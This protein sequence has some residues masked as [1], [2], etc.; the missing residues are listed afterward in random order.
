MSRDLWQLPPSLVRMP[1]SFAQC[2][3]ADE[4]IGPRAFGIML[5]SGSALNGRL[6]PKPAAPEHPLGLRNGAQGCPK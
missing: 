6:R 1:L 3:P 4:C 5:Q 2:L